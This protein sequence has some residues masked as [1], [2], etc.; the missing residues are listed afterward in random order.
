MPLPSPEIAVILPAR[1]AAQ[2]MQGNLAVTF[3]QISSYVVLAAT[4]AAGW[5]LGLTEG[6]Q[7]EMLVKYPTLLPLLPWLTPVAWIVAKIVP[8]AQVTSAMLRNNGIMGIIQ[9]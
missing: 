1:T 4:A 5:W 6:Q 7:A 8:Q 9:K 3:S 2:Q